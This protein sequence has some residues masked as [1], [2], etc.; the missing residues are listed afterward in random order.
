MTAHYDAYFDRFQDN[1]AAIGLMMGIAKARVA[2]GYQPEKTL[3]FCTLAVEE[4]EFLI[5]VTIGQQAPIIKS[6]KFIRIG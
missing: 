5:H 2:S 1:S 3:L 4:W 6:L